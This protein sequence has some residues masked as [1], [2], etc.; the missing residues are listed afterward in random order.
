MP[1][2]HDVPPGPAHLGFVLS[3]HCTARCGICYV[4][5]E[6]AILN[7]ACRGDNLPLFGS[8]E[9]PHGD[10]EPAK[11]SRILAA[12]PM[13]VGI[14]IA[15]IGETLDYPSFDEVFIRAVA[16]RPR[17]QSIGTCT[18]GSK[19]DLHMKTIMGIP[20]ILGISVDSPDP[21]HCDI[22]RPGTDGARVWRNVAAAASMANGGCPRV[23]AVNMIVSRSNAHE[24]KAMADKMASLKIKY[25]TIIRAIHL[26]GDKAGDELAFDDPEPR[27]AIQGARASHPGLIIGNHFTYFDGGLTLA[28]PGR[29]HCLWP[30]NGLLVDPAGHGRPCCR[31]QGPDL[32]DMLT[33]K[34]WQ[35]DVLRRLR[36][37][38]LTDPSG[39]P[40][41]AACGVCPVRYGPGDRHI[42]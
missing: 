32:G 36:A 30:F 28:D 26:S 23:L 13:V 22:L 6:T 15:S 29:G 12:Y 16:F 3:R 2:T 34:P 17:I 33:D 5:S 25:L 39:S 35:S 20:G 31:I 27:K 41:F 24:I 7:G 10:M 4:R 9:M 40:E 8:S 18:N 19:L 38:V 42:V 1:F 21:S 37:T 14:D 11:V